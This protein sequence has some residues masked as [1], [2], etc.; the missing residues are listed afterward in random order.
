MH[1]ADSVPPTPP[2]E[3]VAVHV[4]DVL[5]SVGANANVTGTA[6]EMLPRDPSATSTIEVAKVTGGAVPPGTL[7]SRLLSPQLSA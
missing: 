3:V 1:V 4:R 2:P 5:V 7:S 6:F